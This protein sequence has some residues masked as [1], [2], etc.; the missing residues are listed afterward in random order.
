[1]NVFQSI[2]LGILQGV[3]EFLPVSSSGHLVLAKALMHINTGNDISFEVFVHFGTM[4]SVLVVFRN[5]VLRIIFSIMEAIQH[6]FQIKE[7]YK[8]SEIFRLV[9][10]IIIG[11]IPAGVLGVLFN[12]QIESLFNDAKLV[13]D[14]LLITGLILFLTR[15]SKSTGNNRI[16]LKS[17]L[18][19]GLAQS[20]AILPGISRAGSTI[21][22]GLM[23]N[24]SQDQAARFSF[25][26]ALPV[27][28]GATLLKVRHLIINP[29]SIHQSLILSTGTIVASISGYI[30]LKLLLRVLQKGKFS[31]FSYY[32]FAVGILGLL[33]IE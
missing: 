31:L 21:S 32:C 16:T 8:Q 13:S 7:L 5:D 18:G 14:M 2:L 26:M 27:I 24:V 22:T 25:L 6:P 23:M 29:P 17:A 30:A 11:C 15:F 28:L 1:M 3:T 33:F 4:L 20:V 12:E 9:V 19:V 10:Y